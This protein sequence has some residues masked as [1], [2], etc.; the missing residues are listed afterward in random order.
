M[1]FQRTRNGFPASGLSPHTSRLVAGLFRNQPRPRK[2]RHATEQQDQSLR[3]EPNAASPGSS[4]HPAS[5]QDALRVHNPS[6]GATLRRTT[7]TRIA[8]QP[9]TWGAQGRFKKVEET[10]SRGDV[11]DDVVQEEVPL[12]AHGHALHQPGQVLGRC[13][14]GAVLCTRCDRL[15]CAIDGAL[16]CHE[17]AFR[18][19]KKVLCAH[20][21]FLQRLHFALDPDDY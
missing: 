7:R 12:C 11:F 14:C 6:D 2:A 8:E 3:P 13:Y 20:H 15:Q 9:R 17:H 5:L 18:Q 21:S 4:L 10:R 1:T 19:E 16:V